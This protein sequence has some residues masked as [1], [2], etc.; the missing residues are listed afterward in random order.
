MICLAGP[1]AHPS[2]SRRCGPWGAGGVTISKR[3]C[4][5][6][7][8]NAHVRQAD[9]NSRPPTIRSLSNAHPGRV[10]QARWPHRGRYARRAHIAPRAFLSGPCNT[11][12]AATST[13]R[14]LRAPIHGTYC[15][16]KGDCVPITVS[17]RWRALEECRWTY[18]N[19]REAVREIKEH[20]AFY[21]DR[22]DAIEET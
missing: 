4:N 19:P 20:M 9:Q 6:L 14:C 13:C 15:P 21:P 10:S 8:A 1:E 2:P 18:E 5:H 22:W 16:Y 12:P 7:K 11:S 17:R 3:R